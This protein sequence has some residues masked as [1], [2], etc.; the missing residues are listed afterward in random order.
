MLPWL[1]T[2]PSRRLL[3]RCRRRAPPSRS[4]TVAGRSATDVPYHVVT[5]HT[6]RHVYR[7]K[8]RRAKTQML[9]TRCGLRSNRA[10]KRKSKRRLGRLHTGPHCGATLRCRTWRNIATSRRRAEAP[11][12]GALPP[13]CGAFQCCQKCSLVTSTKTRLT[14]SAGS[15]NMASLSFCRDAVLCEGLCCRAAPHL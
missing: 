2:S 7:S 1:S 12:R 10:P 6:R 8:S 3:G 5:Y 14:M 15:V 4:A 11:H 9:V 13:L